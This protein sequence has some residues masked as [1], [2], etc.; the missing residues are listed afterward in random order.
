VRRGIRIGIDVGSVRIGVARSDP[1][2]M[3]A[4]PVETVPRGRG[5]IQAIVGLVSDYEAIEVLVGFPLGMNGKPGK[6]AAIA[7]QFAATLAQALP[8]ISVR[9]VD[10][11]LTTVQAQRGLKSAGISTRQGR[12]VIDQAAAAIILQ[13][14]L[15]AE[16]AAGEPIGTIV[17]NP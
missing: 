4:V 17:R 14:A 11:R 5:D 7:E 8:L 3:L 15:D 6:A 13:Y 12:N 2:G 9:L 10:E 1:E 16:R